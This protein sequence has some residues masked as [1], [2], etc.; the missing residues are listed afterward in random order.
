MKS[1]M[2][3]HILKR[4]LGDFKMAY[5]AIFVNMPDEK[6]IEIQKII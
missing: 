5:E 6:I 4:K 2:T 3:L 1:L